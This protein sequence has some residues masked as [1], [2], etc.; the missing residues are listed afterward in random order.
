M[1][2]RRSTS[3]VVDAILAHMLPSAFRNVIAPARLKRGRGWGARI[4]ACVLGALSLVSVARAIV[5][6]A[7][8]LD[9]PD[10]PEQRVDPNTQDS[11]W[12]GVGS[13]TVLQPGTQSPQ[14]IY[15]AVAIGPTHVL[16][17]AHVV[18]RRSPGE[19]RFNVNYG[20]DLTHQIP[21]SE[22]HV[23]PDYTG[24]HPDPGSG[25]VHDD[26]AIVRLV[27]PLPFGVPAY[28]IHPNPL[29]ART[30]LTLVG[31]GAGGD[32]LQGVTVGGSASVR[33]VGRNVL[34]S[35]V[36][37]NGG[38]GAFE[39]YL[40]DFDGPDAA[41]N[42]MGGPTLGNTVEATLAGG[43]SGSPAF[44]AGPGRSWWLVGISTFVGP[45]GTAKEKFGGIGGGVL[46]YSYLRWIESV[47]HD[48]GR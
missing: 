42:R 21:A 3:L 12:A 26:L 4:A 44:V 39:V 18:H 47:L 15:T 31:Y 1:H 28:R 27:S 23:H 30:V 13:L 19:V 48:S 25:V 7:A 41:T 9:P 8:D 43:D 20:G 38:S 35:V 11:P 45:Q 34:D 10:S 40:F 22:I 5:G 17:A 33:R 16:T 29:P 24:F 36:R 14:G 32:G 37:D 2:P 46:V 6:G